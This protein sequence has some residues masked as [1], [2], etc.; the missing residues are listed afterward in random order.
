MILLLDGTSETYDSGRL[1][2]KLYIY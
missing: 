2:S 1:N